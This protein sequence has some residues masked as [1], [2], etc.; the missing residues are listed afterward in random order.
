MH[1]SP[2]I[3][4]LATQVAKIVSKP[5][6]SNEKIAFL[7]RTGESMAGIQ[8]LLCG[9]GDPPITPLGKQQANTLM[10]AFYRD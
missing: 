2:K 4:E 10:P 1:K 6:L 3:A 9:L 8:G 5:S 7:V